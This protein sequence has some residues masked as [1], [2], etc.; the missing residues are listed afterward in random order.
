M[1]MPT[2]KAGTAH[3][4]VNFRAGKQDLAAAHK[5]AKE[6]G[7][8]L[9]YVLRVLLSVYAGGGFPFLDAMSPKLVISSLTEALQPQVFLPKD[10]TGPERADRM[11]REGDLSE[12]PW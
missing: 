2:G 8:T 9:S 4:V 5:R 3:V 1:N 10:E 7:F 6:Q 12:P 11:L